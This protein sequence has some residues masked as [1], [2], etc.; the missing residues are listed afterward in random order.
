MERE[1]LFKSFKHED[2]LISSPIA[3][4][5]WIVKLVDDVVGF[6]KFFQITEAAHTVVII[7]S[8]YFGMFTDIFLAYIA[9][10]FICWVQDVLS[11][12]IMYIEYVLVLGRL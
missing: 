7:R 1:L 10:D 8:E 11:S 3:F 6:G 5:E 2:L 12:I 4:K 9:L